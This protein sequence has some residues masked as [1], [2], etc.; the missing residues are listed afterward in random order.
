MVRAVWPLS[1]FASK[2][3]AG[4]VEVKRTAGLAF[5]DR[6]AG[7]PKAEGSA[8]MEGAHAHNHAPAEV[9]FACIMLHIHHVCSMHVHHVCAWQVQNVVS[10]NTST[11]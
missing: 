4:Q 7:P 11:A 10:T 8:T 9:Q 5:R 3:E 1:G 2:N 6:G